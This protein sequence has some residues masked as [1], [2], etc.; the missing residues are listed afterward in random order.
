MV[1]GDIATEF[2]SSPGRML[3]ASVN[4]ERAAIIHSVIN[5]WTYSLFLQA[6]YCPSCHP[7]PQAKGLLIT[8]AKRDSSPPA[9]AQNDKQKT[10]A[11]CLKTNDAV[12]RYKT[13]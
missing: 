1:N 7:E 2:N 13:V 12:Y 4:R 10:S 3:G 9:A 6:Q 5:N 11:I 8:K